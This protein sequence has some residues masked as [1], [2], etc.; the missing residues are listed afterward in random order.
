[1]TVADRRPPFSLSRESEDNGI[2]G[3]PFSSLLVGCYRRFGLL[4]SE[5]CGL[6]IQWAQHKKRPSISGGPA[7]ECKMAKFKN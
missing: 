2:G 7:K 6:G 4:S 1:M 3:L 5:S